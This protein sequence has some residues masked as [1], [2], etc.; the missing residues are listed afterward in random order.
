VSEPEDFEELDRTTIKKHYTN[1][2]VKKLIL[3]GAKL[4]VG[5]RAILSGHSGW[6]EYGRNGKKMIE[7]SEEGYMDRLKDIKDNNKRQLFWT[8]NFFTQGAFEWVENKDHI[9]PGG[10]EETEFY[11]LFMDIDLRDKEKVEGLERDRNVI[12]PEDKKKLEEAGNYA[13]NWLKDHGLPEEAI[14]VYFSGNG[15]YIMLDPSLVYNKDK[16]PGKMDTLA[17]AFNQ[18]VKQIEKEFWDKHNGKDYVQFDA[19]N[20]RKRQFKTILSV[21][22]SNPFIA[23][24]LETNNIE[25]NLEEAT[26]PVSGKVLSRTKEFVQYLDNLDPELNKKAT[27]KLY[28]LLTSEVIDTEVGKKT[29]KELAKENLSTTFNDVD[30]EDLDIELNLEDHE[31]IPPCIVRLLTPEKNKE[32][33][34]HARGKGLLALF[35]QKIGLDREEAKKIWL[36]KVRE[37]GGKTSNIFESWY[38]DPDLHLPR[39]ST[40]QK[41]GGGYPELK[42]DD[43]NLCQD[44]I[45]DETCL[46]PEVNSLRD[47]LKEKKEDKPVEERVKDSVRL[48]KNIIKANLPL[49][50]DNKETIGIKIYKDKKG[51]GKTYWR[52]K[53]GKETKKPVKGNSILWNDSKERNKN[54][55]R[56]ELFSRIK[57]Q[58]S[59][60]NKELD[61][62]PK[63]YLNDVLPSLYEEIKEVLEKNDLEEDDIAPIQAEKLR[64][65]I[66]KMVIKPGVNHK[67]ETEVEL[68]INYKGRKSI[69][70]TNTSE[71]DKKNRISS[72]WSAKGPRPDEIIDISQ[73]SWRKHVI[74]KLYDED[75]TKWV[76]KRESLEKSIA[77]KIVNNLKLSSITTNRE[78]AYDEAGRIL[79]DT[80]NEEEHFFYVF[81][82]NTVHQIL[83]E[84]NMKGKLGEVKK[85]VKNYVKDEEEILEPHIRSTTKYLKERKTS[86]SVWEIEPRVINMDREEVKEKLEKKPEDSIDLASEEVE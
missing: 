24:P 42:C 5:N 62:A 78:E 34:S 54:D 8:T 57:D 68:H 20:N 53:I 67:E 59:E 10:Y 29:P 55:Q 30:I 86:K 65:W 15:L 7:A 22:S 83:D 38:D 40:I 50:E 6:Y 32:F 13:V 23:I 74:N 82:E 51:E 52:H 60:D 3:K 18:V 61:L 4:G 58:I 75:K 85:W 47:Y 84:E 33:L 14:K 16:D 37:A 66:D 12:Y 21:H 56:K 31:R 69:I 49:R 71:K 48:D 9:K 39:C 19:L 28:D 26:P 44:Q 76:K 63:T 17:R 81:T 41:K 11:S 36:N 45:K 77:Q 72:K 35:L 80:N 43:F 79:W 73:T 64:S 2:E 70:Y 46:D 1:K 27:H 25:I